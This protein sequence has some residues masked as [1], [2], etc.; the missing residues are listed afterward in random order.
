MEKRL[1]SSL[2]SSVDDF[3]TST[4]KLSLKSSKSTL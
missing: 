2:H 4:V 1:C 3:L